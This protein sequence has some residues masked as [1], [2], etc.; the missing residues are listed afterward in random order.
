MSNA[1]LDANKA[2]VL[3][4]CEAVTNRLDLDAIRSHLTPDFFDHASGKMMSTDEVIAYSI[5]LHEAFANLSVVAECLVA[6][7]DIVAGRFIWRGIHRAPW[8][9]I[10]RTGKHVEFRGMTFWRIR[11]GKICERWAEMDFAELERQLT[12]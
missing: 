12:A 7:R 1:T 11:E 2:L 4:H 10:P 9:G 3:A 6:E 5:M 8:R